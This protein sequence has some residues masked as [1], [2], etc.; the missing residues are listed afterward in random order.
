VLSRRQ[1]LQ[2]AGVISLGHFS[3]L[4]VP[5]FSNLQ[6]RALRA[7]PVYPRPDHHTQPLRHLW[8]DS[9]TPLAAVTDDWY[10]VPKGFARRS[11]LQPVALQEAIPVSQETPL[12]V[13]A[14]VGTAVAVV[15]QWCA[16]D[17]PCITRI[18]HS[19]IMRLV[20]SLPGWYAVADHTDAV[21]GWSPDSNWLPVPAISPETPVDLVLRQEMLTVYQQ[22][23]VSARAPVSLSQPLAAGMYDVTQG[24]PGGD[25]D[26]Q[27][28]HYGAAWQLHFGPGCT[29]AGTY[30][31][32]D[33]GQ[34]LPG[35]TVQITPA[36]ARWLYPRAHHLIVETV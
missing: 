5:S 28:G 6:G 34:P 25:Q 33:F 24:R 21:L 12:P 35:P 32:N 20:D 4:E 31:H 36:L 18:G 22:G 2:L 15:R 29:L 10:R 9:V 3:G 19:G 8:P 26:A 11:D 27:T 16:A 13:W 1:F 14:E 30:W 23:Q 17:A 7:A